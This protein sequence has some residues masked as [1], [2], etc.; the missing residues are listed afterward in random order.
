MLVRRRLILGR[1]LTGLSRP[2]VADKERSSQAFICAFC[3]QRQAM[4]RA[5]NHC[6]YRRLEKHPLRTG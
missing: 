5:T 3:T 2:S 4:R 6:T 1:D